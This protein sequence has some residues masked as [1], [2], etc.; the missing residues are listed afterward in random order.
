MENIQNKNKQTKNVDE[1]FTLRDI[2]DLFV[3]NWKW[4][5]LSVVLC[6]VVTRLYLASK[7]WVFQRQAVMLVKDE[8]TGGRRSI[9][10]SD[11]LMQLNGVMMGTSVKNEVYILQSYQLLQQVVKKLRLDVTY[12]CKEGLQ[13]V[14]LYDV[15][16][17]EISFSD[18]FK[19]TVSMKVTPISTSECH[20]S[21]VTL[22]GKDVD[23]ERN[24][25]YNEAIN[26]SFG[27]FTITPTAHLTK[28]NKKDITVVRRSLESATNSCR[29]QVKTGEM[30]KESTL[31][32][33]VCIDTN[34]R[35]ADD[36][37]AA[38]LDVYKQ[39]IIEDKNRVAQST[40]YFIDERMD[41]IRMDLDSVETHLARFKKQNKLI[42]FKQNAG[43]FLEQDGRAR[44]KSIQLESQ[45]TVASYLLSYL[46]NSS[47]E[48]ELIPTLTGVGDITIQTQI[49][50][51][52][53]LMLQY[54]RL[55]Q[56]SGEGNPI[57]SEMR[58]NLVQTRASIIASM[59]GFLSSLNV[60][61]AKARQV[62][63]SVNT[64]IS[65]VP[66]KEKEV[67]DI[68]RQ[69]S[70]KETLYTYLLNKREETALQLAITEANIRIVEQPFGSH[71]PISPRKSMITLVAFIVGILL[72]F[73]YF[74]IK[75]MLNMG[76][77][78]RK[79]IEA[80]TT[81]PIL[82]EIPHRKEGISDAKIMVSEQNN[83]PLTE[84]FRMLRFSL[85]FM[86]CDNRV[87]MF[88]STTPGEGKTF[89]SRNFAVTLAMTGKRVI[90]VDTDIRKRTQSKISGM[91]KNQ[92]LTSYL[93]GTNSHLNELIVCDNPEYR[94]DFLPA[95]VTP[96]NPAEL[97]MNSRLDDLIVE[98]KQVYD[99]IIIDNVPALVVADAGIVNRVVDTTL[100]VVREGIVDRRYLPELERLYQEGKFKKMCIVLNDSS[101]ER[102]KYGYGYGAGYGY[103]VDQRRKYK[104]F[105]KK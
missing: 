16:P 25:R 10:A 78:G 64:V 15:K 97:L 99:Y 24:V 40:A 88:T 9:G 35:R 101:M 104:F 2:F 30:D 68:A 39:S 33:L 61:L 73:F 22:K 56:N 21:N 52:N 74:R 75:T 72:P 6:V 7:P 5:L 79:D 86:G 92:G 13:T 19:E 38:I 32:R 89:V 14:S 43:A 69:Q 3:L 67:L 66:G 23:Y 50:K 87:I 46:K 1:I 53:E 62:E 102:K 36:I 55:I 96:P 85:D 34:V 81:I 12:D 51:Y 58:Q 4:F 45:H 103:G 18:S 8:G 59:S 11:A 49:S 28:F 20:I 77:R 65:S 41:Y 98:L 63:Q 17:F 95:G 91:V 42:D 54:N 83:D 93:A 57:V 84:A 60:E 48:N 105:A 27:D 44:E 47:R 100:Y 71:I 80:Y 37:L 90:L 31:V 70:I 82:G 94:V 29:S 76:I 26:T